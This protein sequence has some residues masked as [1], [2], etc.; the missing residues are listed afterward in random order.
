MQY[1][2]KMFK[3][4]ESPKKGVKCKA[5]ARKGLDVADLVFIQTYLPETC[6]KHH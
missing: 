6:K 1:D 3:Y 4:K 5:S 2:R